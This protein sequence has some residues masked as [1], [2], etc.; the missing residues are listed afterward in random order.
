MMGI[1]KNQM[2]KFVKALETA[3]KLGND[4]PGIK[5]VKCK[6]I[7]T[8]QKS[9]VDELIEKVDTMM[10]ANKPAEEPKEEIVTTVTEG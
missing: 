7:C 4:I 8:G 3:M 2:D 9:V 6:L 1:K 5:D 10:K